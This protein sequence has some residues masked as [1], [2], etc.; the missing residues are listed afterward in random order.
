MHVL[1]TCFKTGQLHGKKLNYH[2]KVFDQ[3]FIFTKIKLSTQF[4]IGTTWSLGGIL[5]TT[6]N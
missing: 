5:A 6:E 4:L 1:G 2:T 3:Q